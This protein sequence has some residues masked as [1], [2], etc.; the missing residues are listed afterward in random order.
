MPCIRQPTEGMV[1]TTS[2]DRAKSARRMMI[3]LLVA[4]Q[5]PQHK[6]HDQLAGF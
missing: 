5:P 6:A 2:S 4:D 1:V 3:E